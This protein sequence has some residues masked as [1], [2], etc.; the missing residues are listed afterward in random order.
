MNTTPRPA[1]TVQF[2]SALHGW[3]CFSRGSLVQVIDTKATQ[4]GY[5]CHYR[6]F[7]FNDDVVLPGIHE[8]G[9]DSDSIYTRVAPRLQSIRRCA[10]A[11][12]AVSFCTH[13][14]MK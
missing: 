3:L 9:R 10:A 4:E 2:W 1:T 14:T 8:R 11:T 5:R 6:G 13:S 7:T 12:A